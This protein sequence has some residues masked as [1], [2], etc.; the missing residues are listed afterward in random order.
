MLEQMHQIFT[1]FYPIVSTFYSFPVCK[2]ICKQSYTI[3]QIFAR[4]KYNKIRLQCER[5][6]LLRNKDLLNRWPHRYIIAIIR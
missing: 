5:M 1:S 2:Y 6:K 3:I 4:T